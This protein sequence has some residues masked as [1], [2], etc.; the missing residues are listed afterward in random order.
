V[1]EIK[2]WRF[3]SGDA[4]TRAFEVEK[5][6]KHIGENFGRVLHWLICSA[7]R[8]PPGEAVIAYLDQHIELIK[9]MGPRMGYRAINVATDIEM[10]GQHAA[11]KKELRDVFNTWVI[12][13]PSESAKAK[14]R[15]SSAQWAQFQQRP[16]P[17]PQASYTSSIQRTPSISTPISPIPNNVQPM[18]NI[19]HASV[20]SDHA[21]MSPTFQPTPLSRRP[22]N[23][24]TTSSISTPGQ[25]QAPQST[26][27]AS[28][29]VT[30]PVATSVPQP[31]NSSLMSKPP[32]S[33]QSTSPV[34]SP[35]PCSPNAAPAAAAYPFPTA[36]P[37]SVVRRKA[38]PRPKKK[39]ILAKALD[40]FE[41]EDD[42]DEELPFKE[43]DILE[44]VEKSAALEEEGWCRAKLKDSKRIGLA[45]L[46]YLEELGIEEQQALEAK[47]T[48]ITQGSAPGG[49][50]RPPASGLG[51]VQ[52]IPIQPATNPPAPVHEL[53]SGSPH[54]PYAGQMG[55]PQM[56]PFLSNQTSPALT[57]HGS[58]LLNASVPPNT[59]AS[60]GP[61]SAQHGAY[62]SSQN[63]MPTAGGIQSSQFAPNINQS[64]P[65]SNFGNIQA[66]SFQD[67]HPGGAPAH[68]SNPTQSIDASTNSS[69]SIS[70]DND[71]SNPSTTQN[72]SINHGS[73]SD[74]NLS[75]IGQGIAQA[76]LSH[77]STAR[78]S[79]QN[80]A[81]QNSTGAA[82]GGTST[83]T[84][85]PLSHGPVPSGR[86]PAQ[87][88]QSFKSTINKISSAIQNAAT[89]NTPASAA[90]PTMNL[91]NQT[92]Y[93]PP[94]GYGATYSGQ[95]AS[96]YGPMYTN[97]MPMPPYPMAPQPMYGYPPDQSMYNN[98]SSN[99][100]MMQFLAMQSLASMTQP[101]TVSS[102]P[103]MD[104]SSYNNPSLST[105]SGGTTDPGLTLSGTPANSLG[106]QNEVD[107]SSTD[108]T[109]DATATTDSTT[110]INNLSL[111]PGVD[112]NSTYVTPPP[113]VIDPNQ[114][115]ISPL[116]SLG[117]DPSAAS[118]ASVS[119]GYSTDP[120]ISPLAGL[121]P[122]SDASMISPLAGLMTDPNATAST[123]LSG[124]STTDVTIED[125]TIVQQDTTVYDD[126]GTT[127]DQQFADDE[128][129]YVMDTTA[130]SEDWDAS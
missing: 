54:F 2:D 88:N 112:S 129:G 53:P 20:S 34:V 85:R 1:G 60:G 57:A 114:G 36:R 111:S 15:Q 41:P 55:S 45:P 87:V 121:A 8:M 86:P 126:S 96:N 50:I 49:Q 118:I 38:P 79:A 30:T 84:T 106:G 6:D 27:P 56:S 104:P 33:S 117:P 102:P 46:E 58:P 13:M 59:T 16:Q 31:T 82:P 28:V 99:D 110:D 115:M 124:T 71:A 123:D 22:T 14:R 18:P 107:N 100:P 5:A 7:D 17:S 61:Q 128:V 83:Q 9:W 21:P 42:N 64:Q 62:S 3:L 29:S 76:A 51:T 4:N 73:T 80:T 109:A 74:H 70:P 98:N 11:L 10:A 77:Q 12:L 81:S 89:S 24:S 91:S 95:P 78:P 44:I 119:A 43:G 19:R 72:E 116:A 67:V 93:S 23:A 97:P 75:R 39:L 68:S 120:T 113:V 35:P 47:P 122:S 40:D 101:S 92:T 127:T 94:Q 52:E 25:P 69:L 103:A 130:C 65:H 26:S 108:P 105:L 66:P 32:I 37:A 63:N 48:S 125:T 90:G